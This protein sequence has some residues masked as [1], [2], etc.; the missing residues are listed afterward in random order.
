MSYLDGIQVLSLAINIPGPVAAARFRQLGATVVKV[1][2][3]SGDPL[4]IA[5]PAWYQ[6]LHEGVE[7]E[8]LDLKADQGQAQVRRRLTTSDLLITASRPSALERLGLDWPFLSNAYPQLCQVA[9]VGYPPPDTEKAGHD[10]TYQA[11]LGLVE[12]PT[13]PRTTIADLAGAEWAVSSGAA[14]LFARERAAVNNQSLSADRRFAWVALSDAAAAFAEP[15][16]HGLTAPGGLLGGMLP[17]Y[18]LYRAQDGW[19]AV[20]ALEPHFLRR[21]AET[22]ALSAINHATIAEAFLERPAE[23]WEAW[24]AEHDLP[25]VAVHQR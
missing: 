13:L 11:D 23:A 17:G 1:E 25:L 19:V 2:P 22:L 16:S 10:L 6:A 21:L 18:N 15:L 14:L 24:A 8:Q 3:P 7:V 5:S 20:A 9:I 12:P 4:A